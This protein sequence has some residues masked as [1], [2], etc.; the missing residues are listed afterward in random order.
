MYLTA[1]VV[2]GL[3][4]CVGTASANLIGSSVTGSIMFDGNPNNYFD[5][6]NGGVP[7]GF[8]NTASSTVTIGEPAVEFG[9]QDGANKD[10]ANFTSNQLIVNDTV[11]SSAFNWKMTFTDTAFSSLGLTKIS[12]TF[13]N[14]GVTGTL[15]GDTITL[16]WAGTGS[17][18]GLLVATFNAV[19]E[20]SSMILL[21]VGA[22]GLIA[23]AWRRRKRS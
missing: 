9:Y 11:F 22:V 5:P 6:A 12:D 8:L 23:W 7:A 19:P 2:V 1:A 17:A 20:P 16:T 18:D 13:T 4:S 14:G 21:G 15:V 3:S 10:T